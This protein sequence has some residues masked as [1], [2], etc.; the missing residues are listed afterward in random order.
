MVIATWEWCAVSAFVSPNENITRRGALASVHPLCRESSS[1][2]C[3]GISNIFQPSWT[4]NYIEQFR[5]YPCKLLPQMKSKV[6]QCRGTKPALF[7]DHIEMNKIKFFKA[8]CEK[9]WVWQSLSSFMW[10][11]V[12]HWETRFKTSAR[13]KTFRSNFL[14]VSRLPCCLKAALALP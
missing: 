14:G 8:F 12:W 10:S 13:K 3:I 4:S 1:M 6:H 2:A 9:S 11:N 5:M 7:Q